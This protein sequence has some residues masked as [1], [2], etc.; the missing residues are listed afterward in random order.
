MRALGIDFGERR[1]GVAISDPSGRWALP[2]RTLERDTDR[3]VIYRLVD[4]ARRE[5]LEALVVGHPRLPDGRDSDLAE[6]IQRFA[7]KLEAASGLPLVWVEETLTSRTAE[8]LLDGR[9]SSAGS[10]DAVAAQLI[11]QEALDRE[12]DGSS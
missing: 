12:R 5:Q 4:I 7:S 9:N 1:I 8:E 10:T 2:L 11:L 3:R 6:R